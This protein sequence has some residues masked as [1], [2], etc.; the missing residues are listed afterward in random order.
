M[1]IQVIAGCMWSGKTEE[2]DRRLRRFQLAKRPIF[3][4][5]PE[6]NIRKERKGKFKATAISCPLQLMNGKNWAKI[7][8]AADCGGVIAFD[9]AQFF[10]TQDDIENLLGVV[11][12]L[13]GRFAAVIVAGLDTDFLHRPFG[14]MPYM[15]AVADEITK[16]AAI[17]VKCGVDATYTQ[18]L[19]NSK[20]APQN[21]PLILIG[22]SESYE[23][24]CRNCFEIS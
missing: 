14:A 8:G 24:R 12:T 20:P 15:M 1:P 4:F 19:I 22:D 17:C 18:R 10:H 3:L 11:K 2:L 5:E 7:N 9:E 6:T 13:S 16:L 23:P 21:S